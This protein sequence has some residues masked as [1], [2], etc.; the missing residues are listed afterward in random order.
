MKYKTLIIF[1]IILICWSFLFSAIK[2]FIWQDLQT[3]IAPDLE[4]IAWY[5]S[6]GSAFAYLIWWA[7]SLVFL[8]RYLLFFFA[9]LIAI[10]LILTYFFPIHSS[11]YLSFIIS[12]I[13][14]LYGLWVVLRTIILSIE[15]EKTWI[16]DTKLNAI[17]NILFIIF[18]ILGSILWSKIN[19]TLGH[20]WI[21]IL[22]W[23]LIFT[24]ILSMFLDYEKF[25]VKT[26]IK[27]IVSKKYL[28]EKK[29]SFSQ[30][31]KEFIPQ[32]KYIALNW[33]WIIL[34]S[35]ILWAI[36]TIVSQQAIQYSIKNFDVSASE[37][38]YILLFSSVWA[39]FWNIISSFLS[40]YRWTVFLWSSILMSLLVLWFLVFADSFLHVS[41]LA[42]F[43]WFTFGMASNMIDSYFLVEIW[44]K[45]KKEYWSA[46]YG[47][48]L[49]VIL[50]VFMILAS[51]INHKFWFNVLI[52]ILATGLFVSSILFYINQD[53][54]LQVNNE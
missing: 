1:L 48:V 5:L 52:I 17:A 33:K 9:S 14:F 32:I 19:E 51:W 23:I 39:I 4:S 38:A 44:K 40:K 24:A 43:L 26:W 15:I 46:S 54:A 29:E 35:S 31:M 18:L 34:T 45:D 21:W 11:I 28:I 30:A 42:A 27:S 13:G 3:S 36:T 7:I 53:N 16:S 25:P 8:K 22:I 20:N 49:S 47:F 50:F 41:I 10:L 6:L 12:F 37:W 2:F